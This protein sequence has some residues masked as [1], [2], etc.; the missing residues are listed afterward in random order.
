MVK[1]HSAPARSACASVLLSFLLDYP[2]GPVRLQQH[3]TFILTNT[4]Y[5][6]TD[7]RLQALEMVQQVRRRYMQ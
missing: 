3:L 2:L 1:S 5:E 7:G 6:H 4:G